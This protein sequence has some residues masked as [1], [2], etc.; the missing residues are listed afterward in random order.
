VE[1]RA[2]IARGEIEYMELDIKVAASSFLL[3]LVFLVGALRLNYGIG[4]ATTIVISCLAYL[5]ITSQRKKDTRPLMG[6]NLKTKKPPYAFF[7]ITTGATIVFLLWSS[8]GFQETRPLKYFV[9]AAV[10]SAIIALEIGL[11]KPTSGKLGL[12]NVLAQILLLA[13]AVRWSSL[14]AFPGFV[15]VDP[16]GHSFGVQH[17]LEQGHVY[18]KLDKLSLNYDFVPS[19][20]LDQY[21]FRPIMHI[22][23]SEMQL[24]ASFPSL[25]HAFT[26]SV[27]AFE[28]TS[29]LFVFVLARRI[30]SDDKRA[31]LASLL[32]GVSSWHIRWGFCI[33]PMT[34][35]L[36]FFA[37]L[38]ALLPFLQ[39]S[40]KKVWDQTKM[41]ALFL[42]VF[43]ALLFTHSIASLIMV[44]FL[45]FVWIGE[46]ILRSHMQV[47]GLKRP[48]S[49][50]LLLT[51]VILVA[52][53]TFSYFI[54]D[55][56]PFVLVSTTFAPLTPEVRSLVHME[57]DNIGTYALYFLSILGG[58]N[59]L[60]RL[61]QG[62]ASILAGAAGLSVFTYGFVLIGCRAVL[63]ERWVAFSFVVLA[64]IAADGYYFLDRSLGKGRMIFLVSIIFVLVFSMVISSNC[65]VD[66]PIF[67]PEEFSR[68]S[69]TESEM[70]AARIAVSVS[71][72]TLYL[73]ARARVECLSYF[74]WSLRVRPVSLDLENFDPHAING[75][76][77][78]YRHISYGLIETS[79]GV[80]DDV[81]KGTDKV[82]SNGQ[83]EMFYGKAGD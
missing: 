2:R 54:E 14:F 21:T 44:L 66:S 27:G 79:K 73:D 36:A 4:F 24:V 72:R 19:W 20:T 59:C 40:G 8:F 43:T 68:Q 83:V 61:N 47:H 49:I 74:T 53:W 7:L 80:S 57:I 81:S 42:L 67:F 29:L 18:T 50:L 52:H 1:K 62:K 33:I 26:F 71:N 78:I 82:Y 30:L 31:A 65:N 70:R 77:V 25:K 63:P 15:G 37:L 69:V 76:I 28:V 48:L 17:I 5:V 16:W 39:A 23:I 46:R 45:C 75:L 3:G 10:L 9:A 22:L 35:G 38:L 11:L 60:K 6:V 56:L 51:M 58:L 12:Y 41:Y 55:I 13:A 64:L 32:V 34:M